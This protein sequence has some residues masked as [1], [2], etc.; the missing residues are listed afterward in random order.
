MQIQWFPG[1]MAKTKRLIKENIKLVDLV[2]ELLDARIPQSSSNPDLKEITGNKE[3]IIVLNKADLADPQISRQWKDYYEGRGIRTVGINAIKGEGVDR[4]LNEV[5]TIGSKIKSKWAKRGRKQKPI[6]IIIVGI[7]NVGKS[8]LINRI[9]RR[10]SARIGEKPGV[11]RGKQWIRV[12]R[13]TMLLD[14]PGVL[15][16]KFED[17]TVGLNLAFVGSIKEEILDK[18]EV[19]VKLIERLMDIDD[20]ILR[21][22][23][24]FEETE[25]DAFQ[26]LKQIGLKRGCLM[27]EHRLDTLRAASI[28]LD[29]FRSGKLGR[30]SLERP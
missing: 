11:T 30:I 26:I 17:Q 16:P 23:Y 9:S 15:W 20:Y 21:N 14:T 28:F 22:R 25:K 8:S 2:L 18:E 7:P 19:A 3:K 27:K 12:D 4:L 1:H 24:G 5:R 10:S 13:E 29:D 6:R